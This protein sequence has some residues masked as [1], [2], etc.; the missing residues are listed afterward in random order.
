MTNA[1]WARRSSR[2]TTSGCGFNLVGAKIAVAFLL[3]C[4][5]CGMHAQVAGAGLTGHIASSSGGPVAGASVSVTNAQ[6][7]RRTVLLSDAGGAYSAA[8]LPPGQYEVNVSAQ[9]FTAVSMEVTVGAKGLQA[10]DFVLQPSG[11]VVGAKTVREMPLNGRSATDAAVLEPGVSSARTQASGDSAQHG[12][13]G[14]ITISGG[15]PRQN[16]SRLDGISVNDY[17][18]TPPGSAAGVNLGVDAVAQVAVLASNYPAQFGN[19]SGGIVSLSTR[20]GTKDFHGSAFEFMRNSALDARNYFDLAKPSFSRNQFGGTLGG[21]LWKK[22]TFFFFA[23]EGLRQSLG[24]SQQ[25]TVPSASARAGKLS[26]GDVAVDPTALA[27]INAFYPL[28]NGAILSTGDTG[29]FNFAGQ[30][31]IPENYFASR[32]DHTLS[33]NDALVGTYMHDSATARQPDEFNNIGTGYDSSRQVFT[34]NE[35]HTFGKVAVNS[36]RFGISRVVATDGLSFASSNPAAYSPAFGS[37]PGQNAPSVLV[38]GLTNFTGGVGA[39]NRDFFHWTTIQSYEDLSVV[40]GKH[41]LKAGAEL[42]RSRDNII[43]LSDPG[44]QFQFNSLDDL[45]MN[46]PFSLAATIPGTKPEHG[47]RQW[48]FG[49]YAE[50]HWKAL[51][52]LTVNIGVRYEMATVLSEAHDKLTVLRNLTDAAPHVGSPLFANPTLRD[53]QPRVGFAWNP[54]KD[55]KTV[56]TGGFGIFDVLPLPYLFQTV[57]IASAPFYQEASSTSLPAGSFPGSAFAQLLGE[58]TLRQGY[59]EPKPPRSYVM[60]WNLSVQR[61]I[62]AGASLTVSYVG[63]RSIHLPL[64]VEDADIVLPTLTPQGYLWPQPAN[65]VR[66]NE[67]AGRIT[68]M[69]WRSDAYYDALETQLKARIGS[70]QIGASYT[71]GKTIDTSSGSMV[72]DE[73]ANSVSSPLWFNPAINRGLADFNIAQN[74]EANYNWDI[75]TPGRPGFEALA[76][77]GWQFGGVFEVSTGVPFTATIGGDALGLKSTDP[78]IDVPNLLSGPGCK[79]LSNPGRPLGYIKTQCLAF[80]NPSTLRGNLGRN[81]IIGPGLINLDASLIKNTPVKRISDAFN[82]QFR[83]EFFNVLNHANFAAPLDNRNVFTPTGQPIGNAGVIDSTQTPSREIQLAVK[84]IW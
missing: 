67:N 8:S 16:D 41:E 76:L 25:T 54:I 30:Q 11:G 48:I 29:I 71:W 5:F 61:Q 35:A 10:F 14:Q 80:P 4:Q 63:S 81:T 74:L 58:S 26:T 44:G 72:G 7:G 9:G 69:F 18:N 31:V 65:S 15:R 27:F 62:A 34:L 73:Y 83:A 55:G 33:R 40:R 20:S 75:W 53:F 68:A 42:F 59:F 19:S 32:V 28:P 37:V 22:R 77:G 60:Q 50:D 13:G 17:A 36:F 21:P 82:V 47:F 46:K 51:P 78:A 23:Y 24:I 38:P 1:T 3:S 45:I 12:F 57:E 43:S 70:A 2:T 52:T 79:S 56:V 6:D 64:R 49:A 84:A 39:Q 66:L